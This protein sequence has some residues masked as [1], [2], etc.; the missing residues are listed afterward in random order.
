M[1]PY[2]LKHPPPPN[3]ML[4]WDASSRAGE[5]A[6]GGGAG[7]LCLRQGDH[8]IPGR[9]AWTWRG[10]AGLSVPSAGRYYGRGMRIDYT[11]VSASLVPRVVRAEILGSGFDRHG[12]LGSD[13]CPVLLEL[14][15]EGESAGGETAVG[16]RKREAGGGA[17]EGSENKRAKPSTN[18]Q[19]AI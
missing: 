18:G 15:E 7:R 6:A 3:A 13:H 4:S 8:V 16:T 17:G 9:E 10:A 12:F 19:L 2:R 1:D 11:L 14:R 5:G